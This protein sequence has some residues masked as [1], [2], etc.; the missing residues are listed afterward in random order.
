MFSTVTLGTETGSMTAAIWCREHSVKTIVHDITETVNS[1]DGIN[2]LQLFTQ[3]YKQA[4]TRLTGAARKADLLA[5]ASKGF[6]SPSVSG[7]A[8]RRASLVPNGTPNGIPR[9]MRRTSPSDTNDAQDMADEDIKPVRECV[10]CHVK[11]A[12]KWHAIPN[13]GADIQNRAPVWQCHKCHKAIQSGQSPFVPKQSATEQSSD[14]D[15]NF[16]LW[17]ALDDPTSRFL[18]QSGGPRPIHALPRMPQYRPALDKFAHDIWYVKI[19]V[20]NPRSDKSAI[21]EGKH[22]GVAL[23]LDCST[24]FGY[25]QFFAGQNCDYKRE[26]DVIV[27]EDG[28]WVSAAKQFVL[29]LI[30]TVIAGV[31]SVKWEVKSVKEINYV[32]MDDTYKRAVETQELTWPPISANQHAS[33]D[34][35]KARYNIPAVQ[36]RK[37]AY[38][39]PMGGPGSMPS[40]YRPPGPTIP[41]PPDMGMPHMSSRLHPPYPSGIAPPP[42]GMYRNPHASPTA[43]SPTT[44]TRPQTPSTRP[45]GLAVNG[46]SSSPNIRNLMH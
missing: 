11:V 38:I 6:P 2:A 1:E 39:P 3:T 44:M 28:S 5:Q 21:F 31:Q 20:Y 37:H 22:L 12:L 45:N 19:E 29:A 13:D 4:D 42:P 16:D 27:T 35:N 7:A 17:A 8:N 41:P 18:I 25:V 15:P 26:H 14:V 40:S 36:I 32:S 34:F 33:G 24:P 46:A 23:D 43:L 30:K 10:T 9:T